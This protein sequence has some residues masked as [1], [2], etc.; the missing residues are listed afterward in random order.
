MKYINIGVKSSND[1]IGEELAQPEVAADFKFK[2]SVIAE[3]KVQTYVLPKASFKFLPM[4]VRKIYH[5]V[6]RLRQEL[7]ETRILDQYS[8]LKSIN[9]NV[10]ENKKEALKAS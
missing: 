7:I 6:S 3:H 5:R 9:D 8:Q 1:W 2:Y 10:N 4:K